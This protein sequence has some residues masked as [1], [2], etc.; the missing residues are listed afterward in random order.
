MLFGEPLEAIERPD[1][2]ILDPWLCERIDGRTGFQRRLIQF[3]HHFL[4]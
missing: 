4:L 3:I 1:K 2:F